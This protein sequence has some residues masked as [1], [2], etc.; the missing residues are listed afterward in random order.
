MFPARYF[1][2]RYFA[3]RYWPKVGEDLQH[4]V[5]PRRTI[6]V[7]PRLALRVPPKRTPTVADRKDLLA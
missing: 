6:T 3:G 5:N 7:R 1:P 4:G 2:S